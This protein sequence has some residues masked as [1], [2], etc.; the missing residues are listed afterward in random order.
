MG[1]TGSG[2]YATQLAQIKAWGLKSPA[3]IVID[4][5][6]EHDAGYKSKVKNITLTTDHIGGYKLQFNPYNASQDVKNKFTHAYFT[7]RKCGCVD[8]DG[9]VGCDTVNN[10]TFFE[11]IKQ[12]KDIIFDSMGDRASSLQWPVSEV[13]KR[14]SEKKYEIIVSYNVVRFADLA[15]RIEGR[16]NKAFSAFQKDPENAAAPR[17][18]DKYDLAT[19]VN[20][21]I[22]AARELIDCALQANGCYFSEWKTGAQVRLFDN[23]YIFDN[24]GAK[25]NLNSILVSNA[26][27]ESALALLDQMKPPDAALASSESYQETK[28]DQRDLVTECAK[29]E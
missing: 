10:E 26:T 8:Y 24:T 2:K 18:P 15:H 29:E 13:A 23:L 14:A 21:I 16:A 27:K 28:P 19:Y 6:I 9:C 11:A 17:L 22:G 20:N 12:S 4:D 25:E 1:P 7:A 5:L 3:T